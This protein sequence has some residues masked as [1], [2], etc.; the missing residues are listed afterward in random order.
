[1]HPGAKDHTRTI[2]LRR[3]II[4][5]AFDL[6][7]PSILKFAYLVLGGLF[8]C[9]AAGAAT[10]LLWTWSRIGRCAFWHVFGANAKLKSRRGY[11]SLGSNFDDQWITPLIAD[12]PVRA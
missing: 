12:C 7:F 1:M 11:P 5:I 2:A 8:A 4:L 6:V 3:V 10:G 9:L